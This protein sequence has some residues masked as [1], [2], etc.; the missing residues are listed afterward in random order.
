MKHSGNKF[1]SFSLIREFNDSCIEYSF[2]SEVSHL[3]DFFE[4]TNRIKEFRMLL[5]RNGFL[6][7]SVDE[8]EFENRYLEDE[9]KQ[10]ARQI[11][12]FLITCEDR[13]QILVD[14]KCMEKLKFSGSRT[15]Y[16]WME[17]AAI[18]R[19]NALEQ[20]S[21]IPIWIAFRDVSSF[22]LRKEGDFNCVS[23]C[24]I[25]DFWKQLSI[26]CDNAA[27]FRDINVVRIPNEILIRSNKKKLFSHKRKLEYSVLD[28]F[29]K[30]NLDHFGRLKKQL[31][32]KKLNDM[33]ELASFYKENKGS[34]CLEEIKFHL[35]NSLATVFFRQ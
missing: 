18:E 34:Y 6:Y 24:S 31:A 2:Q 5:D 32:E 29:R 7:D 17:G 13:S 11:S 22:F 21:G 14:L 23:L 1:N 27:A 3:A 16:F 4:G 28:F 9:N 10:S 25:M 30:K 15:G 26:G 8:S 19:L 12:R 35:H 33:R 20:L